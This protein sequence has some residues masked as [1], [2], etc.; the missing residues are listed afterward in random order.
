MFFLS[1][2][3]E[4]KIDDYLC[5]SSDLTMKCRY[6]IILTVCC[7]LLLSLPQAAKAQTLAVKT[8]VLSDLTTTINLGAEVSL[9][10]K[11]SLDISGNYNAWD[12]KEYRKQKHW[13]VQPEARFWFCETFNGHFLAAHVLGGEFNMADPL[14]PFS[15]YKPLRDY[16][17]QGW[18]YGAGIGYGYH[19]ILSPR[20]SIEAEIGVGYVG[21][22]YEQY[23]CVRCGT[24]LEEGCSGRFSITKLAVSVVFMIF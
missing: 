4:F 6:S 11:W 8:N 2:F 9:A 10:P 17:F 24:L 20:W 16:R 12:F 14:F 13:L 5:I 1:K 23:E 15:L 19:W 22:T 7:C 3:H 21:T 18:M